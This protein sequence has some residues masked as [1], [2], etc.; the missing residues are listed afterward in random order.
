MSDLYNLSVE[1]QVRAEQVK[2]A[3]TEEL[4]AVLVLAI[5]LI[6]K[7]IQ[8]QTKDLSSR[9]WN[10]RRSWLSSTRKLV[11]KE[12]TQG[13]DEYLMDLRG[14]ANVFSE[15]ELFGMAAILGKKLIPVRGS[16]AFK[17]ATDLPMSTGG[18]LLLDFVKSFTT[19][20]T[21]RIIGDLRMGTTQGRTN[22][23]LITSLR[24]TRR[25]NFRDGITITS[26]R[27]AQAIVET[28]TQHVIS[29]SR[30]QAWIKNG[31]TEY[32]WVS[33]L[34]RNTTN[35]CR[36]LDGQSFEVGKGPI[37]PIHIR[38]RST[39]YALTGSGSQAANDQDYYDWLKGRSARFQ[40]SVIGPTRGKLLRDGGLTATEFADLNLSKSFRP[41]TLSEMRQ[42]RP[43]A[44]E[45]ARI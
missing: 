45:K 18:Q 28:A 43:E 8:K 36:S 5:D 29:V 12:L 23:E 37:P 14:T 2:A 22:L 33:V 7:R 38:C 16:A 6:V 13:V 44:F 20:E 30:M 4:V 41:L 42:L 19:S 32:E 17:A 3:Q 26:K 11:V 9:P 21:N 40:D 10:Y 27:N 39:I 34:D 1:G 15:F 24:G 25:R 31:I 35:V